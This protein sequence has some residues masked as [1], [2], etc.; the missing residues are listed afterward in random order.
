MLDDVKGIGPKKEELL[1]KLHI[2]SV[3]DLI[4]YYPFRYNIIK[5]TKLENGPV[6]ISGIVESMPVA[7][8][9]KKNFNKM[10]FRVQIDNYLVNIVIFNRAFMKNSLK[11]GKTITVIGNYD[12]RHN[13][14]TADDIKFME[15]KEDVYEPIYHLTTGISSKI[16]NNLINSALETKPEIID[17]IPGYL[18]E[19]YNF[20]DKETSLKMVHNPKDLKSIK[21]A[22][23]RLK[24]EELF[25]FMFKINYLKNNRIS[26]KG[27]ERNL[28]FDEVNK[29]ISELPFEL[30]DDQKKACEDILDDLRSPNR[31]NRLLLGD[32]GSGKT[33]VSVIGIFYNY[34]NNYQSALLAPTEILATQHYNNIINIFKKYDVKV[35]LLKGG[36]PKKDRKEI[37]DSLQKG[38]I[39]LLIGTHAVL[40]EDV[41]FKNLGLVITDE[42][43]RFGVN[44]RSIFQNKGTLCD[45]LYMSATPIPR[46]YALTIYGDMDI[47]MIKVKPSGRKEIKTSL[48]SFDDIKLVLGEMLDEIKKGH[49][50]YI[51]APMIETDEES[52]LQGVKKLKTKIDEA[53]NKKIKTEILHG[54]LKN[55]D[56]TK[57]MNDF[58]DNKI[59]ILISTTVIEVGVDVSN[60]T[61]MVI[62]NAERFGLATLHQLRGRIGRNSIESKCILISDKSS[63]RLKVL[64][65]SND[66]FYISE[67]DFKMRGEGDLFGTQQSGDM[68]FKIANITTD[69]K[70]LTQANIDSKKFIEDRLYEGNNCYLN[71]IDK[72]N[73]L[74]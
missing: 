59:K 4:N 68:V 69:V 60:A 20:L 34:L 45:I 12:E 74:D 44:Q 61:M 1:N 7:S 28:P 51:V 31:M 22:V 72:L 47:S 21:D 23:L 36:M 57:I 49:Q 65:E 18:K 54:K 62:F 41:I 55:A 25:K 66:G 27:L 5:R 67:M 35:A 8:Y 37:I 2:N 70:I 14:I 48:Y 33:I 40:E 15:L 71:I 6:A 39:D 53:Y 64:T 73:L 13:V 50:I 46:T 24:Y 11:R 56:K 32:V 17:Y 29:F 42:Q 26:K 58:K 43:H 30:T 16:L 9:I 52:E 38:E 10:T 63:D 19:E 3:D